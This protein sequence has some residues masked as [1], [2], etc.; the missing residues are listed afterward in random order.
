[1]FIW[2]IDEGRWSRGLLKDTG[3]NHRRKER[4]MEIIMGGME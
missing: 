1:M 4:E 3:R 2:M